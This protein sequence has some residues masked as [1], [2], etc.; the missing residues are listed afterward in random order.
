MIRLFATITL[1]TAC[2]YCCAQK[3]PDTL[4]ATTTFIR[5]NPLGFADVD[6]MNISFGI[7]KRVTKKSSFGL[8]LGYIFFSES[9]N[10]KS[11]YTHGFIFRP[12]YRFFPGKSLFFVEGEFHYK[13][14][15]HKMID[16]VGRD[17][18]NNVASYEEF[19]TFRLRKV[20]VGGNVKAGRQYRLSNRFWMELY[21]GLGLRIREYSIVN[22]PRSAYQV[23][24]TF[25]IVSTHDPHLTLAMPAGLRILYRVSK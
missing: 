5:F 25:A 4:S 18:V 6:D 9:V 23:S 22:E 12:A 19:A 1:I 3:F 13:Q 24:N 2:C 7:E 10:R 8:D 11:E 15:T 17:A 16:W 14:V 20:T 21:L